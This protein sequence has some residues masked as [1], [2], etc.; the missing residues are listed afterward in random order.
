MRGGAWT[1]FVLASAVALTIAC[2][3]AAL[4]PLGWPF[5]LFVHFRWQLVA[6]TCVLVALVLVRPQRA[7][8]LLIVLCIALQFAPLL[9]IVRSAKAHGTLCAGAPL[10]IATANLWFVNDDPSAAIEWLHSRPADIVV[11]Q[12]VTT[13]WQRSLESLAAEFPYRYLRSREDPYGI[14]VLSR[15]PL[16]RV[17]AVDFAEDGLPS[18]VLDVDAGGTLVRVIALHTHWPVLPS[19]YRAR[20]AGLQR[21]A[22]LA[23]TAE[24]PVILLGDLNLTP[25]APAFGRLERASGLRDA[26]GERH[27]RPT[28]NARLWPLALPIDH[29][30]VPIDAC[31]LDA[32]IG[33]EIG[34]DHRPVTVSLR[35]P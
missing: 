8:V 18:L 29:V 6:A 30:L 17:Q 27:W 20:D 3:C 10:R 26:L 2:T 22:A 9:W 14:G 21:A 34:S 25:Y 5:E 13:A 4:A 24:S 7:P 33:P 31:V 28:W 16:A 11:V 1:R 32:Q 12:E 23:R 15:W 35:W 19:L